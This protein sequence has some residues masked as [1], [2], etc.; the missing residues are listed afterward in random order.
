M[1]A[2]DRSSPAMKPA[3]HHSDLVR[4]AA[5]P[6]LA[7][8]YLLMVLMPFSFHVGGL[9]LTPLRLVLLV[10]SVPLTVMLFTGRFGRVILT[11]VV[12]V[13]HILWMVVAM[14][15]NNPDRVVENIG[16]T[17]I[18]FLGGYLIA[19][20]AIRDRSDFIALCKFLG[21]ILIFLF[22]FTLIETLTG[23]NVILDFLRKVPMIRANHYGFTEPRLGLERAQSVLIHPIHFGLYSSVAFALTVVGLQ[24]VLTTRR[25]LMTGAVVGLS[26]FLSLSSGAFLSLIFQIMLLA[27]AF[28]FRKSSKKWWILIGLTVVMY[29]VIDILSNRGPI[30]VFLSYATFSPHTAYWRT[31]IFEWGLINVWANPVFGLG[32]ND[33]VRPYYMYSGSMD[34]YFL[35]MA[36]RYGIPG[37]VF[38]TIGYGYVILRVVFRDFTADT[39]LANLRR[40]WV[41]TF[42]GLTFTLCTVHIWTAIY[43]FVFFML[44]AGSWFLTAEP[45]ES[46]HETS[47]DN[48]EN[49]KVLHGHDPDRT[50]KWASQP[51]QSRYTR[52]PTKTRPR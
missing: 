24:G 4:K 51:N 13:L 33:W 42:I 19:R 45:N 16:S 17:A 35:V 3:A 22:P 11:D 29:I 48:P 21:I 27:W 23:R 2:I 18:E 52:F 36:V 47:D 20:A 6:G 10:T 31:I 43:S 5:L 50:R 30:Q 7:V 25:R 28:V 14:S 40:A 38:V 15:V 26:T 44:G 8:V 34:N 46:Q 9:M 41:F 39:Q 49:T 1:V 37:F 32:L 12:F